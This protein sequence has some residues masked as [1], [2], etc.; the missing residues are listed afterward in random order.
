MLRIEV[1]TQSSCVR[2]RLEGRLAGPWVKELEQCCR[3]WSE[4]ASGQ[5]LIIDLAAVNYVDL[6]GQSLLAE[7]HRAGAEL[8]ADGISSRYLIERIR[9]ACAC[10]AP[11]L[12]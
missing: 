11:Q 2:L 6:E 8:E 12:H 3:A 4:Q 5:R 7:L 10:E 9:Q 1:N